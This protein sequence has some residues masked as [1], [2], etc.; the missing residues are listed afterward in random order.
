MDRLFW[1]WIFRR[2]TSKRFITRFN[3]ANQLNIQFGA[4]TNLGD[5]ETIIP[6]PDNVGTGLPF[7]KDKLTTAYSP[8]NFQFTNTSSSIVISSE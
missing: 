8:L 4:G 5:D 1:K 7:S 3:K 2:K 6:N